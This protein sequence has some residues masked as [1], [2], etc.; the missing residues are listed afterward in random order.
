MHSL[1]KPARDGQAQ[2]DPD[3]DG[4]RAVIAALEGLEDGLPIARRNARTVVD[5]AQFD[6]EWSAGRHLYVGSGGLRMSW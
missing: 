5:Y 6:G 2:A 1:D 3:A 4:G